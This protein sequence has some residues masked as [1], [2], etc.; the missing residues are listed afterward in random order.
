MTLRSIFNKAAILWVGEDGEE[1]T[2]T[3]NRLYREV[4]RFANALR[5][6][7]VIGD[8]VTHLHLEFPLS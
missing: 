3:Y 6:L 4:N 8:E 7:G 1:V 5:R 2:Y